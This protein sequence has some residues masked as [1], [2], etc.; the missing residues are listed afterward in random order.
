MTRLELRYDL[1]N[2]AIAGV[3]VADRYQAALDQIAWGEQH[4]FR[5][6]TLSEHHG[7][8][9]SYL[10]SPFVFGAAVAA[11]TERIR[12]RVAAL[13]APLHDPLRIAEDA[14]VLDQLSRGRLELV[15]A[16]GYVPSEFAMFDKELS[17][18]V[19]A[20]V[21][22]IETLQ[23]AWTGEPFDFRGRTVTVTPRPFREPRPGIFLGGSSAGAAR[24]AARIADVF[25]PSDDTHWDTYRAA[26]VERGGPDFGPMP[27]VA[28]RFIH[29]CEDVE[30]GWEEVGPYVAND[31]NSYGAWALEAGLDTG[32][33]PVTDDH[34][35]RDDPEYRVLTP[36]QCVELLVE[37]GPSATLPMT[38]M[39]GGVPPEIAWRSLR[40]LVERVVPEL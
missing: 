22:T 35:L 40:L 19:P 20:V 30:Q 39:M 28:P 4:G 11:R 27:P 36:E 29:V 23:A 31:R 3:S 14:A 7:T 32:H 18:R 26:V 25:F 6:V 37:L 34:G 8:A 17:Q 1:R 13:I 24:R 15:V 38:P 16:N 12:I 5:T 33:R 10:P 21:E 9:D 2:P